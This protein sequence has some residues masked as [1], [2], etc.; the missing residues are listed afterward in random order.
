MTEEEFITTLNNDLKR[1]CFVPA[2]QGHTLQLWV[3]QK[4]EV[5]ETRGIR[6]TVYF[7]QGRVIWNISTVEDLLSSF[8]QGG[9]HL[10]GAGTV[11]KI[12]DALHLI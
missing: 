2:V 3:W 5:H 1:R 11:V 10:I 6:I 7:D 4:P 9:K 12:T 8:A